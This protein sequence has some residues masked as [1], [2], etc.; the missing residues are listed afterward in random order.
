MPICPIVLTFVVMKIKA[1]K[2]FS[3]TGHSGSVYALMEKGNKVYSGSSDKF[4]ALWNL[5]TLAPEKLAAKFPAII[6]CIAEVPERNLLL[7]GT[8]AGG[9]HIIDT[10]AKQEIKLL[11]NHTGP[12][13]A[14]AYSELTKSIYSV[15]GDGC[16]AVTSVE[17]LALVKLK[18]LCAEKVRSLSISHQRKE[19]ADASGDGMIRTFDLISL[20]E[21]ACFAAHALSANCVTYSPDQK[22]ILSGGRDAHL[23]IWDAT[24]NDIIR[25]IAAHNFAIYDI[26]FSPD[27]KLFATASRDKTVK[28]WNAHTFD[29]L[30]RINSE[31]HGGHVNSVN[32][33]VWSQYNNYL[34]STGDDR[35]IM[36]WN[37][38]KC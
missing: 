38:E 18:K 25:K 3:F 5:E 12:V 2:V 6:Y 9:I 7:V 17:T 29:L 1:N 20:Q 16:F 36:V 28:I 30:L 22:L 35:A 24:T 31:N 26:V 4:M 32:K 8:S 15:G 10:E 27:A 34:V 11:Q 19:I 33:L 21:L 13:F 23:N 14:M 37:I